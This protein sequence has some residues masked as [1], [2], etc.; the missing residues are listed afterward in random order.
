MTEEEKAS[1]VAL[2]KT[3]RDS[4]GKKRCVGKKGVLKQS[5]ILALQC[6]QHVC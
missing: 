2:A 4:K 6:M 1:S 3:Y 5:Q